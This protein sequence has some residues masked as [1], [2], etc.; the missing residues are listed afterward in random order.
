MARG[1]TM[2]AIVAA[3]L[4]CRKGCPAEEIVDLVRDT[5][6]KAG[7]AMDTLSG[8][9]APAFKHGETGLG[10]AALSLGVPLVLIPEPLM[11]AAEPRAVTVSER[12]VALKGLASIAETAALAGAGR[13]SRLVQPRIASR[14]ATCAI[15][16]SEAPR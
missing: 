8:L 5:M 10:A 2:N 15:A 6:A 11:K 9:F 7:L 1:E 4:G 3:G 16:M 12:V 14:N 13:A